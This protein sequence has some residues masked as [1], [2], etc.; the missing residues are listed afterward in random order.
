MKAPFIESYSGLRS[1]FNFITTGRKRIYRISLNPDYSVRFV[2]EIQKLK[3]FGYSR[4]FRARRLSH[5][6]GE[7]SK[8]AKPA[9]S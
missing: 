8:R 2:Q 1:L 3:E 4:K 7:H 6:Y 5:H 9:P